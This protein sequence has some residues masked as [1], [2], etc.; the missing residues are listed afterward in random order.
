MKLI[1]TH[2]RSTMAEDMLSDLGIL[3]S[4][5]RR[6]KLLNL[7]AFV[8]IFAKNHKN[9]RIQLLQFGV[10]V[11]WHCKKICTFYTYVFDQQ[12]MCNE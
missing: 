1:K 6:A 12:T 10:S 9:R 8:D 7:D 5:R 3:R 4:E 11:S 2:L